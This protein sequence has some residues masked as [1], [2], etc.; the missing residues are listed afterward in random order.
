MCAE[1]PTTHSGSLCENGN[2]VE[3]ILF[4]GRT[5]SVRGRHTLPCGHTSAT[6]PET[7]LDQRDELLLSL[8]AMPEKGRFQGRINVY[9]EKELISSL[10]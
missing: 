8:G 4:Y 1:R 2:L 3:T 6:S 7:L 10:Y 9:L 5:T